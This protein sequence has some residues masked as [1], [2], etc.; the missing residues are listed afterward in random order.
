MDVG[1]IGT[2]SMGAVH[3]RLLQTAVAGARVVAAADPAVRL[4]GVPVHHVD[5]EALIADPA[6]AGVVIASPAPTH[7]PLV[8]ACLAA[9]KPVLCEKPLAASAAACRRLVDA[10]ADGLLTL[11][12]MRR[13]DPAYV[14]LRQRLG[15]VGAPRL[16]HMVHR[17]ASFRPEFTPEAVL[18]DSLVHEADMTRWLLEEEIARVSVFAVGDGLHD[19]QTVVFE[20]ASGRVVDVEVFVAA[21]YGYEIRCEVVGSHGT[22]EL[23]P[24]GLVVARRAGA[25]AAEVPE[26]FERRFGE[27]YR[28]ELQAW[29][30]GAPGPGAYDGYAA[31]AV[32]EA[33]V[34]SLHGGGTMAVAL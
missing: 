34:A 7:E 14:E 10:D 8:L 24:P 15:E 30:D 20:T 13:F 32:C 26:P 2:G 27:A 29:V 28:R 1:V 21:G 22:L 25:R 4:P 12:F 6:V 16:V 19:P 18:T 9:G 17:N 31:T 5:P 3:V 11:G 23:A 33:A